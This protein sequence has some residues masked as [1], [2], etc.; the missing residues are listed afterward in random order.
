MS[1]NDLINFEFSFCRGEETTGYG[2]K[3]E[4]SIF[5]LFIILV[6]F[7]WSGFFVI[8]FYF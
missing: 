2:G 4:V 1:E 8:V 5:Q 6:S 3:E 7:L